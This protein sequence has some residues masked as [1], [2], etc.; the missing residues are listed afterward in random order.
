MSA[1]A[2]PIL[3]PPAE[4]DLPLATEAALLAE[5]AAVVGPENAETL[6]GAACRELRLSRPVENLDHMVAVTEVLLDLSAQLRVCAR[7]AKIRAIT[8]RAFA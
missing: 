3:I 7:A 8:S 6:V 1:E 4:F 2:Q 5:L